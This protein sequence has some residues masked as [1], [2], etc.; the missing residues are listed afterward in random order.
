MVAVPVGVD[1]EAHRLVGEL[2]DRG[3]DLGGERGVLIVDHEH[4]VLARG[5]ADVP[6]LPE[7]HVDAL[8][9][10]RGGDLDLREILV[11]GPSGRDGQDEC[12]R[13]QSRRDHAHVIPPWR[14]R[15]NGRD[16]TAGPA[17]LG[18]E[19]GMEA[20]AMLLPLAL[21]W[22]SAAPDASGGATMALNL[23][24]GS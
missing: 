8:R 3:V 17:A 14:P 18:V 10:L 24:S 22:L 15:S 21:V 13:G 2:R 6:A 11:L 4:A 5:N 1:D 7:Q 12:G 23:S 16:D 19:S 20:L 9:E